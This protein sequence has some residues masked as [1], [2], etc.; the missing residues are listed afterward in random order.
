MNTPD[1]ADSAIYYESTSR[2]KKPGMAQPRIVIMKG[3]FR[4]DLQS[5][6]ELSATADSSIYRQT[7]VDEGELREALGGKM[8]F[9]QGPSLTKYHRIG[10]IKIDQ[11]TPQSIRDLT[12]MRIVEL[13]GMLRNGDVSKKE[14]EMA[15]YYMFDDAARIVTAQN[16]SASAEAPQAPTER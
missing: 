1:Q 7:M 2:L 16:L 13:M 8:E 15:I 5:G 6:V 10:Q 9:D 3:L 11:N 12:A 4:P 14:A